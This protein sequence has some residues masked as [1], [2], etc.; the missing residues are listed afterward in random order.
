MILDT[1]LEVNLYAKETVELP[2][3][4]KKLLPKIQSVYQPENIQDLQDVFSCARKN[5]LSIIPRGAG[6]SGMGGITPLKKSILT[7]LSHLNR[8]LHYDKK[9]KTV[10]VESG[11]RW[12]E[13]KR[14]LKK[15][16]LDLYTYPTSLFSTVGGW[17]ATGGCGVNSFK[18]GHM[19]NHVD[20]IEVVTP[21]KTKKLSRRNPEFKYFVG[22]EGQ[23]GI[24]SKIELKIRE[25][26][27]SK[28]YLIFFN[29][30][31]EATAFLKELMRSTDIQ[32]I[33]IAYFD[34][35]R[36][37]HKNLLLNPKVSF[38]RLEGVLLVLEELS[39][40]KSLMNLIEKKRGI[41]AEDYLTAFL[42]NERFFP[43]SIRRFH[44][45]ILGSEIILPAK[46]LEY[47]VTSTRKFAD[48]YGLSLSTEATLI[49]KNEAVVFSLFPSHPKKI[50]HF[51][52]LFL[53][54]S[55]S[56][57]ASKYKGKPYGIGI[58]N[59]PLLNKVFS[60]KNLRDYINYKKEEDPLNVFNP[61]KSFSGDLKIKYALRLA[62]LMSTLFSNSSSLF[63]P[64]SKILNNHPG[65]MNGNLSAEEACAN[66]GACTVVCPAYL[67]NGNE[68]ITAKGKLLLL[69]HLKFSSRLP[70]V[71]AEKAFLCLHC[72]LC[73]HVCQSKLELIPVWEKLET[74]LESEFGRPKEKIDEFIKL[75]EAHPEYDQFLDSFGNF[76]N[77]HH[78][79]MRNV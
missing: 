48:N 77:N 41:L 20:S 66:C 12:W 69:K 68:I 78:K 42:W 36:L 75:F 11:L 16:S 47:Y 30:N 4:L 38:P 22:T 76:S 33:H 54:Y 79:V 43:F 25:P 27:R 10:L 31:K 59:L 55:L 32:P 1:D 62:Y 45:S 73:E 72:H 63:K 6:T 65:K 50:S 39:T 34:R 61:G 19:S 64:F 74:L 28:P 40:E 46:N 26:V 49:N 67:V 21:H 51:F 14:F 44:P 18:Y 53:S 24:V 5:K 7:D 57:I 58:W 15:H 2:P 56:H 52:H 13:L 35:D 29:T 3:I 23:M 9:K 8:I 71:L 70:K 37:E 60:Q 17:L